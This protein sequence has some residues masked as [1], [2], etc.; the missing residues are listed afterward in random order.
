M[1]MKNNFLKVFKSTVLMFII[2]LP[3]VAN[4]WIGEAAERAA[5]RAAIQ[6]AER[7]AAKQAS[8]TAA[9]T[10]SRRALTQTGD[11]VVK[12]WASA[13]CKPF[14]P[15]PLPKK[16]ANSFVGGA[17]DEVILENETIFYR[18]FHDQKY[19]FGAPGEASYWSC[20]DARGL[21]AAIDHAIPVSRNGNTAEKLV[22]IRVPKGTRLFEG[23]AQGLERGTTG[24]GNQ[25]VI[26]KVR[27][28]WEMK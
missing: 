10:A 21:Q 15:C 25:V 19:K 13:L 3:R 7:S 23:K 6:A 22:T 9:E 1:I 26:E 12:R 16:T 14:N 4:A 27:P 24:G 8:K 5:Q 11:R 20:S 2:M 17:Y 18:V 28:E